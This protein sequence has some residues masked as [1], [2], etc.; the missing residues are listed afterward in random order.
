MAELRADTFTK[1]PLKDGLLED[2]NRFDALVKKRMS[3][4]VPC[5]T[6]VVDKI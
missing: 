4:S 1:T 5:A 2:T 3:L 6:H